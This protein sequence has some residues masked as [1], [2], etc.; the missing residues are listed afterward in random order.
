VITRWGVSRSRTVQVA[1]VGWGRT[2]HCRGPPPRRPDQAVVGGSQCSTGT[3]GPVWRRHSPRTRRRVGH[4]HGVVDRHRPRER[5][6]SDMSPRS[7]LIDRPSSPSHTTGDTRQPNEHTGR[8]SWPPAGSSPWPPAGGKPWALD[9]K[10][11]AHAH[12]ARP[13]VVGTS[14]RAAILELGRCPPS[15]RRRRVGG[16]GAVCARPTVPEVGTTIMC[17]QL[18]TESN[19]GMVRRWS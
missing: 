1:T 17:H 12:G 16:A 6:P 2:E 3:P 7:G 19:I 5:R 13:V 9:I 8:S 15:G 11:E 14:Q 10:I 4:H 18:A